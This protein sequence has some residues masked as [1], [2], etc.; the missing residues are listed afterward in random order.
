MSLTDIIKSWFGATS[1]EPPKVVP[2][3]EQLEAQIAFIA[4]SRKRITG[5]IVRMAQMD[6]DFNHVFERRG[7]VR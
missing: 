3:V 4:S 6:E 7:A 5:D 2:P 1:V